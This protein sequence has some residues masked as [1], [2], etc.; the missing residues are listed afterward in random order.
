MHKYACGMGTLQKSPS[1]T[2]AHA[3]NFPARSKSP[4]TNPSLTLFCSYFNK[5]PPRLVANHI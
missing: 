1:I 3:F 5:T 2:C 4:G